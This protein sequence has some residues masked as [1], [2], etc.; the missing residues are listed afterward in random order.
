MPARTS[1]LVALA[2]LGPMLAACTAADAPA[3]SG[4]SGPRVASAGSVVYVAVGASDTVGVGTRDPARQA[5]PS[6]F[7][8]E[9]LPAG[10]EVHNLGIAGA[11]TR[12]AIRD[13]LPRALAL[14]P[15]I[16]TVWLNVNDLTHGVPADAYRRRLSH[17]LRELRRGGRTT[18]LVA[19]TPQL[20]SLPA[21]RACLRAPASCGVGPFVPPPSFVRTAVD[22]YNAAIRAAA[23]RTGSIVVDLHALGDV[24][25]RHPGWVS[26]DGFHPSAAGY[27]HVAAAFASALAN[28]RDRS[29]DRVAGVMHLEQVRVRPPRR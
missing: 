14:R 10:A 24:P 1:S 20:Q 11:T 21:Y 12:Q 23:L 18:V 22:V 2:L 25:A 16:V 9:A 7:A 5:W 17:L 19:T 8:R 15:T 26:G 28:G 29:A 27:R 13:E 4:S 6:V 3:R